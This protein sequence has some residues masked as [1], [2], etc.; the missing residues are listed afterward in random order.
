MLYIVI[1]KVGIPMELSFDISVFLL[2]LS[3][4]AYFTIPLFR[5]QVLN[6]AAERPAS[7]VQ[8]QPY[9]AITWCVAVHIRAKLRLKKPLKS[10]MDEEDPAAAL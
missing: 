6:P 1:R 9:T 8:I 5:F 10:N 4:S 7:P 2:L 3:I